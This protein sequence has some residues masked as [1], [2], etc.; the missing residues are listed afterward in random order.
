M[1]SFSG[2]VVS[3]AWV[4]NVEMVELAVGDGS[5]CGAVQP[6][7]HVRIKSILIARMIYIFFIIYLLRR[8]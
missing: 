5:V 4:G 3:V 6:Q 2:S 1:G 7:M 8:K